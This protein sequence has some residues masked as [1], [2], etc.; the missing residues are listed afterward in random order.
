M[1]TAPQRRPN[2]IKMDSIQINQR[3]SYKAGLPQQWPWKVKL[4]ERKI[5]KEEDQK[6]RKQRRQVR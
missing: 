6:K 4:I 5:K 2:H 3:S 1:N